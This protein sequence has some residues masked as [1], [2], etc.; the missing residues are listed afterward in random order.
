[1]RLISFLDAGAVRLGRVEGDEVVPVPGLTMLALIDAG[2]AG[3]DRARAAG[4]PRLRLADLTLAAPIPEPRRNIM[5]LGLNYAEHARESAE[6]RGKEVKLPTVPVIFTK[7]TTA[8]NGPY[9]DI[10]FDASVSEAIDWE[11]ELAVVIGKRGKN[12]PRAAAMAHVFGYCV[13]N[14]VTAR[15]MQT[16]HVQFFKGKSLDG[17]CPMGPWI[18]TA[19]E[20][21]NPNDLRIRCRVNGVTKQDARTSQM[22]FDIPAIVE[23]LSK[24]MTL[25]P[26]DI[27]ATGTPSGVGFARTPPEFLKPGDVV[28]CEIERV[29]LIRNRVVEEG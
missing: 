11:A 14:D 2:P 4:G 22:I 27:L 9:A 17:A 12:I 15:D 28:E 29:G 13:L 7:A 20:V 23:W 19:D 24:G 5:C 6:A 25:L 21:P 16:A 26:G 8:I 10:P 1:M 18:V 3:L